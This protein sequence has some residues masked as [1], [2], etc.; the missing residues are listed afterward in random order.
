MTSFPSFSGTSSP[1]RSESSE[2]SEPLRSLCFKCAPQNACLLAARRLWACVR[3]NPAIGPLAAAQTS[4]C[5]HANDS[6]SRSV[7][8]PALSTG[9][10]ESFRR[11]SVYTYPSGPLS[12][13]PI[14]RTKRVLAACAP[15]QSSYKCRTCSP[16]SPPP[17]AYTTGWRMRVPRN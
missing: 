13:P 16:L 6:R 12:S 7:D 4:P 2:S 11:A 9:H 1:P 10:P 17:T 3:C 14:S 8:I 15:L 5:S